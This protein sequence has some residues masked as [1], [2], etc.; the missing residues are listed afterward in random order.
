[1]TNGND[2]LDRIEALLERSIVA[3]DARMTR[4]EESI[5]SSS[6]RLT[7]IEQIVESN[8]R[9]LESFSH[10]L[11]QYATSMDNLSRRIDG[12]IAANN[13]QRNETNSRLASIQRQVAAISR[14]LGVEQ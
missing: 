1:M 11:Q 13:E 10:S 12:I 9:F 6:D 3:S 8:N 4:I 5:Q 2:R 14:H 7:R